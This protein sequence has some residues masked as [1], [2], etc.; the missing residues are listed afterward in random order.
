MLLRAYIRKMK[1]LLATLVFF[2]FCHFAKAQSKYHEIGFSLLTSTSSPYI[3]YGNNAASRLHFI[4]GFAY[5]NRVDKL[6]WRSYVGVERAYEGD[7]KSSNS[8]IGMA[9]VQFPLHSNKLSISPLIDLKYEWRK[10]TIHEVFQTRK[11]ITDHLFGIAPGFNLRFPLGDKI[12]LQYE[13]NVSF[14]VGKQKKEELFYRADLTNLVF[15]KISE[16]QFKPISV[17]SVNFKL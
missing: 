17:L 16:I 3:N 15:S 7:M 13:A 5:K 10:A 14:L 8:L 12:S 2:M 4:S 6:V 9:G 11:W 1:G